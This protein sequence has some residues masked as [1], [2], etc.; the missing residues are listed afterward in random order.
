MSSLHHYCTTVRECD[1][2]CSIFRLNML[3]VVLLIMY[4]IQ[5]LICYRLSVMVPIPAMMLRLQRVA[6]RLVVSFSTVFVW[7]TLES[8]KVSC[9][10]EKGTKNILHCWTC[11]HVRSDFSD[12]V[13]QFWPVVLYPTIRKVL[14]GMEPES[15]VC[16][17]VAW[18]SKAD[19][20]FWTSL[21]TNKINACL[22]EL[23][24]HCVE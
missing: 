12:A 16:Q 14:V 9:C 1:L 8:G 17:S 24:C 4:F 7:F 5:P 23:V 6:Q 22:P 18:T 15:A 21:R 20:L 13:K 19:L 10:F 3:L 11:R 2:T